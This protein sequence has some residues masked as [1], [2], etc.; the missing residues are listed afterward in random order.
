MRDHGLKIRRRGD[1]FEADVCPFCHGGNSTDRRTFVVYPEGNFKCLRGSC[2]M[3]GTFWKLAEHYG[4][5]PKQ[6]FSSNGNRHSNGLAHRTPKPDFIP[7]DI[8]DLVSGLTDEAR[9]Y[10]HRRGFTDALLES[11]NIGCNTDGAIMFHYFHNGHVCLTKYRLPKIEKKK[12]VWASKDSLWVLWG[13]EQCD[14]WDTIVI[15]FGEYD[16]MACRQ[17]RVNNVVSVPGGDENT[18]WITHN[19]ND[20]ERFKTIIL[21]PDNDDSGRKSYP[22]I[23]DRLGSERIRVVKTPYKDA[24][25]MLGTLLQEKSREEAEDAIYDAVMSAEWHISGDLIEV[26]DIPER[27]LDFS[28]YLTGLPFLNRALHGFLKSQLTV[29]TGDSK[30]GKSTALT[31]IAAVAIQ[32]GARV[33]AWSG[34]DD[35]YDYKYRM[36]IHIG[37]VAGTTLKTS[38]AGRQYAVLRPE[39]KDRIDAF[40]RGRSLLLNKR[41]GVT[42]DVLVDRFEL[43]YKRNGCDVFIVDN[44][45]K[46]VSGKDTNQVYFR[47]AQIINE[48]SDFAKTY[49]VHVHIATHI[50]KS[51]ADTE[52]PTKNSVSGAKEITNLADNVVSWWRVPEEVKHQFA[53]A[54]TVCS[55]LANRIF[56]DEPRANLIY[57][58]RI[59]RFGETHV[60]M[61]REYV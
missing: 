53:G 40:L 12:T 28:G 36:Y 57:D 58:W 13:I 9:A 16:R 18:D 15:T 29:H 38:Q 33:C 35:E 43:A 27:E 31:Q 25:Q 47:Q 51:G 34:E 42:E 24:N 55:V 61:E 45:M 52:P 30:A 5:D 56:G 48:L 50:N 41:H 2:G 14:D 23:A 32:Q 37:G 6:F 10:L 17:A 7:Q 8:D 20:L 3:T 21:W 19:W 11:V 26:V 59:K 39:W 22:H 1:K 4:D 49:K 54:Q 44:L 46:I 60:E